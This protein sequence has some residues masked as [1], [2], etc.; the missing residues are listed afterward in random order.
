MSASILNDIRAEIVSYFSKIP[1]T[2]SVIP[3]QGSTVN[4][5]ET[6]SVR[7]SVKNPDSIGD[8]LYLH[9][10]RLHIAVNNPLVAMLLPPEDVPAYADAEMTG[11]PLAR[12]RAV[13]AMVVRYDGVPEGHIPPGADRELVVRGRAA[14]KLSEAQVQISARV[15]AQVDLGRI[16]PTTISAE[17]VESLQVID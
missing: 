12:E 16:F 5:G 1:V 9:K 7:V 10:L 13:K 6:F 17:T 11:Q 4:P 14:K 8:G 2:L 15:S 3:D